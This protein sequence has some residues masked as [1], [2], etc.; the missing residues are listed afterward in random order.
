M[1]RIRGDIILKILIPIVIVLGLLYSIDTHAG[2]ITLTDPEEVELSDGYTLCIYSN[3]NYSFEVKV[4]G[5][6]K[7]TRT[8][9]TDD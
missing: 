9:N 1:K 5:E 7:Y 6:C 4:E 3:S 2:Q 8:F